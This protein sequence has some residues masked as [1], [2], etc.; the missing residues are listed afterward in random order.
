MGLCLLDSLFGS[1]KQPTESPST[2]EFTYSAFDCETSLPIGGSE[3]C[4]QILNTNQENCGV[5]HPGGI[6]EVGWDD[7]PQSGDYLTSWTMAGYTSVLMPNHYTAVE[8]SE[9]EIMTLQGAPIAVNYCFFT[10]AANAAWMATAEVTPDASKG[11]VVYQLTAMTSVDLS[12]AVVA[13]V[14]DEGNAMGEVY[15]Q[16]ESVDG[17]DLSL[18]ATSTTGLILI[19]NVPPGDYTLTVTHA[20]L[21]CSSAYSFASSLDNQVTVPVQAGAMTNGSLNCRL[22]G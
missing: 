2:S 12:G 11:Q 3:F 5:S 6:A 13:L 17:L 7:P 19:A 16:H 8:Y 20:S 15:Y 1:Q 9:W 21:L 14:D 18:E 4:D 10:E 22:G